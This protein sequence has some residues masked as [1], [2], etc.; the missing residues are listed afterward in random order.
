M[1]VLDI[2]AV[3]A[4][5]EQRVPPHAL[6]QVRVEA[7]V[8][9]RAVTIVERRAPWRA[10]YGLEWTTGPIAR[11]RC[12]KASGQW[13]PYWRDRNQRWHRYPDV[14][15]TADVTELLEEIDRDPTGSSGAEAPRASD[16]APL[17]PT[18][19]TALP[20]DFPP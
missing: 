10:D 18:E 7:V 5:C 15:P 20:E 11:L 6:H 4:Y 1:P 12:T 9:D 8:G 14:A 16:P 17:S 19:P 2:A 13:T 3:R